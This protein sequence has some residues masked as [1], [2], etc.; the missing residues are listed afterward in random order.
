ME[1]A[2]AT[3]VKLQ[4]HQLQQQQQQQQSAGAGA[5][6]GPML[7]KGAAPTPGTITPIA[8]AAAITLVSYPHGAF[9]KP[10]GG[11]SRSPPNLQPRLTAVRLPLP[12]SL[13]LHHSRD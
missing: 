11:D 10:H 6:A 4:Q 7:K 1:M 5:G 3:N 8:A 9:H 2:A 12:P 13:N